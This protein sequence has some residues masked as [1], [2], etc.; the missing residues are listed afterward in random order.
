MGDKQTAIRLPCK[1]VMARKGSGG[2]SGSCCVL[3]PSSACRAEINTGD[4]CAD[5]VDSIFL[6][7]G[8][9]DF[10]SGVRLWVKSKKLRKLV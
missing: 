1:T 5:G 7:A 3:R 10:P 8:L 6:W 2:A 4:V 9:G